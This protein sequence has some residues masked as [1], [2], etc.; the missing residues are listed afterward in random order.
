MKIIEF[1]VISW[2]SWSESDPHLELNTTISAIVNWGWGAK[3]KIGVISELRLSY[4]RFLF[5]ITIQGCTPRSSRGSAGDEIGLFLWLSDV[6]KKWLQTQCSLFS[7]KFNFLLIERVI[8][9]TS[10]VKNF[11]LKVANFLFQFL[12]ADILSSKEWYFL[13]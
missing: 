13:N 1:W 9:W 2:N 8:F 6:I 5:I 10:Q 12:I 7:I 4:A 3:S 11:K